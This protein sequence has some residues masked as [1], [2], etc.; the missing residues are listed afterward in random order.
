VI[1]SGA[2][3][4]TGSPPV[5][6]TLEYSIEWRLITAGRARLG[7]TATPN[8]FDSSF[9][10]ESTGLISRFFK[11]D[12]HY[13]SSLDS[14]LCA[15]SSLMKTREGSRRR[16]SAVTFDTARKKATYLERDLAKNA[17]VASH[18]IDILPC[19]AD[20]VG[21]LYR[22]RGLALDPGQS[23]QIPVSDGKKSASVKVDALSREQV[24]TPAGEF[25][26]VR[27]EAHLF[28]GVIYRRPARVY[29]WLTDDARRLPVQ[30]QVRLQ[31]HIG[32]VTLQL[33]K[34]GT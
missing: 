23:V 8:G 30:I 11:V 15:Q 10:L 19:A 34:E 21:A 22:L 32:T 5:S 24:H 25:K 13:S 12:N 7:W 33:E 6:E 31:F 17:V 16:E 4:F 27:Y 20:V 2:V 14:N 1:L 9:S 28:D 26:T 3:A 18:E 29:V